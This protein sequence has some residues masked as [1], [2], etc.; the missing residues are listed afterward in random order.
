[1][2]DM[3]NSLVKLVVS[4]SDDEDIVNAAGSDE[5]SDPKKEKDKN[6]RPFYIQSNKNVSFFVSGFPK[7]KYSN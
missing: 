6:T 4:I 1:M 7:Q 3:L 2:I 5:E